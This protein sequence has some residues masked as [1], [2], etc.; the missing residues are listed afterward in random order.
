MEAL[1]QFLADNDEF[2]IDKQCERFLMSL[3]P[4]GYLRRTKPMK[5]KSITLQNKASSRD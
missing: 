2:T 3:N 5:T 4:K 1:E